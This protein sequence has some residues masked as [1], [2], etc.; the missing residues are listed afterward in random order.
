MI[1]YKVEIDKRTKDIITNTDNDYLYQY[2][3]LLSFKN[4]NPNNHIILF[5]YDNSVDD[6]FYKSI[7]NKIY[8]FGNDLQ[9]LSKT[10]SEIEFDNINNTKIHIVSTENSWILY[11]TNNLYNDKNITTWRFDSEDIEELRTLL[12]EIIEKYVLNYLVLKL[13]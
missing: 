1:D 12:L 10:K 3:V 9:K 6:K 8:K 13:I 2:S 7:F 11:N 4:I 5:Y